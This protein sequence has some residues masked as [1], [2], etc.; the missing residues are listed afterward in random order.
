MKHL[1]IHG[2]DDVTGCDGDCAVYRPGHQ[3]HFIQARHVGQSP[4]GWRDAV[5][6]SVYGLTAH[7]SYV[8][9]DA[10]PRVWHHRSL[11]GVLEPGA[12]VRLHERLHVLGSPAGWFCVR[13]EDGLGPAPA[14]DAPEL[15]ADQVSVGVVDLSTGVAWATDHRPGAMPDEGDHGLPGSGAVK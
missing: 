12:P 8:D 5:V 1:P 10:A 6:T 4:W 14:P 13:V 3:V 2:V 15:W 11:A 7:L 9:H